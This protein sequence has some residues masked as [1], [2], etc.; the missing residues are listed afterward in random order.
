MI[1]A[2]CSN[3]ECAENG[4]A[5]NVEGDPTRVECG[6][7]AHDCDLSDPRPDPEPEKP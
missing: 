2:Q 4:N 6:L 1:T 5:Y 3:T 7:C